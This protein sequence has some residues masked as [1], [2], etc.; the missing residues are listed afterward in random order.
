MRVPGFF[1]VILGLL[2]LLVGLAIIVP[3]AA[4]FFFD[5]N[6][7]KNEITHFINEK[8]GLPL[9]IHGKISMQVFPWVG[10][11]VHH[12]DLA[13]PSSFGQGKMIEVDELGL[14]MPLNDLL[15][16]K[17]NIESLTINGLT[18]NA[19]QNKDGSTNWAYYSKQVKNKQTD[20]SPA[21]PT[22]DQ[23][24]KKDEKKLSFA[25]QK[26][27]LKNAVISFEDRQA[28]KTVSIEKLNF[29]AQQDHS[30]SAYNLTGSL[31][32]QANDIKTQGKF[33]GLVK[34][35]NQHWSADIKTDFSLDMPKNPAN[36]RQGN[37]STH[38]TANTA[39]AITFNDLVIKL[40]SM[41]VNGS[42]NVPMDKHQPITFDLDINQL[43]VDALQGFADQ[44][45]APKT[46]SSAP[47]NNAP[48]KTTAPSSSKASQ[49]LMGEI[50]IQKVLAHNLTLQNV[51][52]KVKQD[53]N[54]LN[55]RDVTA[56]LYQGTLNVNVAKNLKNPQAPVTLQ[57]KL[58][59]IALTPLLKDLKQEA[60]VSGTSTLDFNLT[61]HETQGLNGTVKCQVSDG[62]IEGVDVKYYLSA[63]QA[64]LKKSQTKE[65]D[66]KKT[67]FG[68]LQATLLFNNHVMDNNDLVIT[69]PDFI[70]KGEGSINLNTQTI[71]YKI[72]ALKNYQDG[73][74]HKNALPLALRI[75][76][77]LAHPK[78]EPD[79]DVYLK[80]LMQQEM[81]G[82]LNEQLDKH[83]GKLLGTPKE[84]DPNATQEQPSVEDA[85]KKKLEDKLNKGLK[86]LFKEK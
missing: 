50:K 72:Q 11:N 63:A 61:H 84:T 15:H 40:G 51:K 38:I 23:K 14:K 24:P 21:L 8:T 48:A 79:F 55:I 65:S 70:A 32:A 45:P 41:N 2:G 3:I 82:K 60:R 44:T 31:I 4:Y 1:R 37:V 59:Q 33:S 58:S 78:V 43:D 73:Q 86:K 81:K 49:S 22:R 16:K 69:S 54:M 42:C 6:H 28:G 9:E 56:N 25:L 7:F 46:T 67:P 19:I 75:K 66:T 17:L 68:S 12:V 35:A 57:G 76:G 39:K 34:E 53:A 20:A 83:L 26:F 29:E 36:F 85:A 52:A 13:Q 64:L 10:L 71:A 62:V 5:P 47:A 30:P 80:K 74:E 77:P 27:S 18:I